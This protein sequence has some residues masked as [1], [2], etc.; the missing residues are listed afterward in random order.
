MENK[1][2]ITICFILI[3]YL[4]YNQGQIKESMTD[5]SPD[6]KDA[7]KQIYNADVEAIRNLSNVATQLQAG[8]LVIPGDLSIKGKLTVSG[9]TTTNDLVTNGPFNL[10][11][12]GTVVAFNSDKAP[13]GWAL[14]DGTNGTPD[15]RGRF[16]RM[17]SDS[18]GG[19]NEWGGKLVD[20]NKVS[21][22]KGLGGTSR[23]EPNSWILNN[24]FGDKA[25][26]DIHV[27]HV[28]EM[29]QH[30][31][32]YIDTYWAENNGQDRTYPG[33]Q[34]KLQ[35]AN[36]ND[37]DNFPLVFN[38]T[39]TPAGASWGHNNQPPYY[40]LSYIMKL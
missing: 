1:V 10:I 16:I 24:K 21:Y 34:N 3:G 37:N 33:A 38:R 2:L 30:V 12:A 9:T 25:G 5:V 31:H 39:T 20:G 11:P 26:T 7:I 6:I 35:G 40:V 8:G 22:D 14:C 4:F 18:L 19:F 13:A 23:D 17:Q 29:P 32:P 28:N 15:L 36:G 27:L